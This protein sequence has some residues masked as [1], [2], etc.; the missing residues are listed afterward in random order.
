M[1]LKATVQKQSSRVTIPEVHGRTCTVIPNQVIKYLLP[2]MRL[3]QI[4][5]HKHGIYLPGKLSAKL[6]VQAAKKKNTKSMFS[7]F[8]F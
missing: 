1:V 6:L 3:N 4:R 8:T 5:D 7:I 2:H